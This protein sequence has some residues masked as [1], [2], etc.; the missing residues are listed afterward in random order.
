LTLREIAEPIA[1]SVWNRPIGEILLA[2]SETYSANI[3]S[4]RRGRPTWARP[5]DRGKQLA[6]A[7]GVASLGVHYAQPR[8]VRQLA[9]CRRSC[10]DPTLF[11]R[12]LEIV[13]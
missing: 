9:L 11:E 13:G 1:C 2:P 10:P 3:G 12:W 7:L 5:A 4:L 8:A 6:A